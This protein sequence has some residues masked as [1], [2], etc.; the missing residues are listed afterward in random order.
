M[1]SVFYLVC[2]NDDFAFVFVMLCN[3]QEIFDF[4]DCR[5]FELKIVGLNLVNFVSSR[6]VIRLCMGEGIMLPSLGKVFKDQCH[7]IS[8]N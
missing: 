4:C 7:L 3:N 8:S 1:F 6:S 2:K 5:N